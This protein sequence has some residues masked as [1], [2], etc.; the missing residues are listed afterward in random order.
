[1][2][3]GVL[4]AHLSFTKIKSCC[5]A[6][7]RLIHISRPSILRMEKKFGEPLGTT[8]RHGEHP[9]FTRIKSLRMVS[10]KLPGTNYRMERNV[11]GLQQLGTSLFLLQSFTRDLSL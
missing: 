10:K 11:G 6:M 8:F 2:H 9:R 1:M 5:S 3:N 7:C 4:P